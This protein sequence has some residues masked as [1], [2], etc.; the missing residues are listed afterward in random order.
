MSKVKMVLHHD[1]PPCTARLVN[2]F[3]L[4]CN[5]TPDMQSTCFYF[6]CPSCDVPLKH[7]QC[8]KCRKTFESPV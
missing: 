3:C 2:G 4:L 5:L 6:Y 1:D 7:L 8:P